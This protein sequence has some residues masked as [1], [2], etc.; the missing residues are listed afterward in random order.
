[1]SPSSG[2]S[3]S[4]PR[5]TE[6][7]NHCQFTSNAGNFARR[8]PDKTTRLGVHDWSALSTRGS[9]CVSETVRANANAFP[10]P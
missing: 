10:H 7:T 5:R 2:A 8:H 3:E 1:M 4:S 6:A 9:R